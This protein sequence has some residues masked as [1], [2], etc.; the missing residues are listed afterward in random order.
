MQCTRHMLQTKLKTR[1]IYTHWLN[2]STLL[3][4]SI[5]SLRWT[6]VSQLFLEFTSIPSFC[7]TKLL[8]WSPWVEQSPT[9]RTSKDNQNKQ[10]KF[11]YNNIIG[12]CT[13]ASGKSIT[14][15]WQKC[16]DHKPV[17]HQCKK[18]SSAVI[19][20]CQLQYL[21]TTKTPATIILIYLY[22]T[23]IIHLKSTNSTGSFFIK[24]ITM[25]F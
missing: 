9:K 7:V 16:S 22:E 19:Q 11:I 25:T 6:S 23:P 24:Y 10:C 3:T 13:L 15:E 4:S 2:N 1:H 12:S 18:Q 21:K 8:Y 20:H 17:F 5:A 14:R